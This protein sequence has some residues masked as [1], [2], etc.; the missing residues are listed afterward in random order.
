MKCY[1]ENI[2]SDKEL[3]SDLKVL[4]PDSGL[5][6]RMSK[7]VKTA[8]GTA[9]EC[10]GGIEN[11]R[12]VDAIITST[13]WGCLID[14][15]RFLRNII[16]DNEQLL[17]P[18]P[19]IQSTFNTVGGQIALLAH[20]QSY[21]VTY[22]N[23]SHSFEDALLD[24]VLRIEDGESSSVLVGSYDE[25]TESQHK[26]MERMG[27][28]KYL[29]D[30]EGCVFAKLTSTLHEG[31]KAQISR[32]DFL[33]EIISVDECRQKYA[34]CEQTLVLYNDFEVE[35]IYPT[36]S[37]KVLVKAIGLLL[38]GIP[39]VVIYNSYWSNKASVIVLKCI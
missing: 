26:I 27:T 35:G 25:Q 32:I 29:K 34:S 31:C 37:A 33:N 17:N 5:R 21:N 38:D 23:R 24:A 9:I 6:R 16:N 22:V 8:V 19:F 15:E 39:E 36:V 30:G 20:N 14:S 2:L 4:I 10:A 7:I 12:C 28:Y 18:T 11:V 3:Y 1:I 13:G